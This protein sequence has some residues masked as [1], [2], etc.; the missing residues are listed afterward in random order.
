MLAVVLATLLAVALAEGL[1]RL[2]PA[3]LPGVEL[4]WMRTDA[5]EARR[6][7]VL[8]DTIGFRPLLTSEP[9]SEEAVF[10]RF[11]TRLNTHP[12][13]KRPGVERLL[14]MGDSVTYRAFIIDE[15]RKIYGVRDFEYW[16]A[17]VESY[18]TRQEVELF[19]R[20]NHAIEPDH[21]VL[22]LH[23]NDFQVTPV[24]FVDTT[25]TLRANALGTPVSRFDRF[26][27]RRSA[28]YRRY[29]SLRWSRALPSL[30]RAVDEFRQSVQTL[31][32]LLPEGCRFTVILFPCLAPWEEWSGTTKRLT[33]S[34]SG[35]CESGRFGTLTSSLCCFA[36]SRPGT[37]FAKRRQTPGTPI[38]NSRARSPWNWLG[39]TSFR[40]TCL[41]DKP[42]SPAPSLPET[43]LDE[44]HFGDAGRPTRTISAPPVKRD[45]QLLMVTWN[46]TGR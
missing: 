22:T 11:G 9:D 13:T 16:N 24:V 10:S 27:L 34:R 5:K 32:E 12:A 33:S 46:L 40:D 26:L 38:G 18:N 35:N 30:E 3:D 28:L 1:A 14:F 31:T 21:V 6:V 8:D 41:P 4:E 45:V 17:G 25:G 43:L 23:I 15:L 37:W 44:S 20:Y 19:R 39:K 36:N 7:W 29:M 42:L 2:F